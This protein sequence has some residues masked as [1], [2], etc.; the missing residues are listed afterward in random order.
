MKLLT[1][2]YLLG[3]KNKKQKNDLMN[4]CILLEILLTNLLG[5][6]GQGKLINLLG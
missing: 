2:Q 6:S 1:Q 5:I 4:C 3:K